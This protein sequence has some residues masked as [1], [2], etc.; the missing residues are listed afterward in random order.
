MRI[1]EVENVPE[2]V[3]K[4]VRKRFLAT[5]C[6]IN[7]HFLSFLDSTRKKFRLLK[8]PRITENEVVGH[9]LDSAD[10]NKY[11]GGRTVRNKGVLKSVF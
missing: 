7:K 6:V 10:I 9:Q 5:K 1:R 4:I 11:F 3:S 8:V 2:E